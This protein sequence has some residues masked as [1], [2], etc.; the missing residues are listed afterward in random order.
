MKAR[1]TP[2]IF[3]MFVFAACGPSQEEFAIRQQYLVDSTRKATESI[4]GHQRQRMEDSIRAVSA[5]DEARRQKEADDRRRASDKAVLAAAAKRYE[6]EIF[7]QAQKLEDLQQPQLLRT[8]QEKEDQIRAQIT[9]VQELSSYH[10]RLSEII[11]KIDNGNAY[12]MP[13]EYL[14][15]S[16]AAY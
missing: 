3:L 5:A 6:T 8:R 1:S 11:R 13:R 4:A 2:L 7:V 9:H 15:D 12:Q 10:D 14:Q 16:V